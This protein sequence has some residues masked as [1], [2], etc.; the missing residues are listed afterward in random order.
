M[1]SARCEVDA[2]KARSVSANQR[3]REP[4]RSVRA[5]TTSSSHLRRA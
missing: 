5:S 1:T 4:H 3:A 2:T